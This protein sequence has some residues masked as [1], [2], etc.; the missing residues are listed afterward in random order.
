[1]AFDSSDD[2]MPLARPN[3]KGMHP[4]NDIWNADIAQERVRMLHFGTKRPSCRLTN[5]CVAH[6]SEKMVLTVTN[7]VSASTISPS[8]D[9]A[10]DRSVPKKGSGLEG[11]SNGPVPTAMDVD[12]PNHA[13]G[14]R[15]RNSISKVQYKE[16]S[17]S[18]GAPLVS[19][20]E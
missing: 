17:D 2:D 11:I 18:D 7:L 20:A 6:P 15:S 8:V 14:K 1:M 5:P 13:A 10:L 9:K 3:G 19:C 16:D 4:F 12:S